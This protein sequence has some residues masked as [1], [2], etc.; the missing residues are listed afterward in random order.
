MIYFKTSGEEIFG[1]EK[2]LVH[3][4]RKSYSLQLEGLRPLLK[5]PV[6]RYLAMNR[7]IGVENRTAYS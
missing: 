7:Y 1:Y 3:R 5:L 2:I 4:S 6:K